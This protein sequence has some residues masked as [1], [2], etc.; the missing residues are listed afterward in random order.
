MMQDYE[1][2][3]YQLGLLS[4]KKICSSKYW[5]QT[6]KWEKTSTKLASEQLK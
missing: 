6:P 1:A 4:S 5:N 2:L 3:E